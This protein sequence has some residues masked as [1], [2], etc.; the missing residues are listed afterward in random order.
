[1][2][3]CDALVL[4]AISL[5]LAP[6]F[7]KDHYP[8]CTHIKDSGGV[9]GALT[10]VRDAMLDYAHLLKSDI[11]SYYDSID[12]KVLA[13]QLSQLIHCPILLDLINQYCA[14]T[15]IRDGLYYSITKGIPKGCA[16][17]PQIAALYLKPLDEALNQH[18]FYVR[19]MDDWVVMIRT[20]QQLRKV[21]RLTHQI[22]HRLK[23][24]MHPDKTFIGPIKRGFDFLGMHFNPKGA[25]LS[26]IT[27]VRHQQQKDQRYA[28][29]ANT[30]RIGTYCKRWLSWALSILRAAQAPMETTILSLFPASYSRSQE[31]NLMEIDDEQIHFG[32]TLLELGSDDGHRSGRRTRPAILG[33][34]SLHLRRIV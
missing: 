21:V 1:M 28:Q 22:L 9:Q 2:G 6:L 12:Q 31:V 4:K 14:R 17:S 23:C 30:S 20:K 8:D 26:E 3:A 13:K 29:G 5:T 25:S 34:S 16:L 11:H 18:G 7:T 15:E 27:V 19:F 32:S 33:L 10:K 24:A